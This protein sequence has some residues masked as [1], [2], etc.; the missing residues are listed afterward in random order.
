[1]LPLFA[2]QGGALTLK[3][4]Y[5][6]DSKTERWIQSRRTHANVRIMQILEQAN[7]ALVHL[8]YDLYDLSSFLELPLRP[9]VD[10]GTNSRKVK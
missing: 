8:G 5:T 7:R 3:T 4:V 9:R 6:F 2:L 10:F 1:M